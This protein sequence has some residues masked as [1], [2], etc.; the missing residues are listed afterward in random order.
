MTFLQH[1]LPGQAQEKN[2]QSSAGIQ[3][4]YQL[5][6]DDKTVWIGADLEWADMWVKEFQANPLGTPDNVRFQGQHYD[7]EVQSQ[8]YS[9]FANGEWQAVRAISLF[10]VVSGRLSSFAALPYSGRIG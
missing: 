10:I 3:T 6:A 7:F 9:L 4:S 5:D 2:G 8:Q 1:Y